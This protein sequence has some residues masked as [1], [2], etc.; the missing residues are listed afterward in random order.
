MEGIELKNEYPV[1]V[2]KTG[3]KALKKAIIKTEK[4]KILGVPLYCIIYKK[5]TTK[6]STQDKGE[7]IAVVGSRTYNDETAVHAMVKRLIANGYGIA[8]GGANGADHHALTAILRF[9]PQAGKIFTVGDRRSVAQSEAA[10]LQELQRKGGIIRTGRIHAK[11][12]RQEYTAALFQRTDEMMK[13]PAV[14]GAIAFLD[15]AAENSGTW[16]TVEAAIFRGKRA[17]VCTTDKKALQEFPDGYWRRLEQNPD[18]Y[19]WVVRYSRPLLTSVKVDGACRHIETIEKKHG[20][21]A[22]V[23]RSNQLPDNELLADAPSV[24]KVPPDHADTDAFP[25]Y[26][27]RSTYRTQGSWTIEVKSLKEAVEKVNPDQAPLFSNDLDRMIWEEYMNASGNQAF[28]ED[29]AEPRLYRQIPYIMARTGASP[30]QADDLRRS[31]DILGDTPE[32]YRFYFADTKQ[33]GIE[34]ALAYYH[35]LAESLEKVTQVSDEDVTRAWTYVYRA[36][37][38][39]EDDSESLSEE[40]FDD[41]DDVRTWIPLGEIEDLPWLSQQPKEYQELIDAIEEAMP[42]DLPALGKELYD[43]AANF[44]KAQKMVAFE[45]YARVKAKALAQAERRM[46]GDTLKVKKAILKAKTRREIARLGQRMHKGQKEGKARINPREWS[47]LWKVYRQKKTE[48]L[49]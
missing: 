24:S 45:T 19:L 8:S 44:T 9:N 43:K 4:G 49:A 30:V 10:P 5:A 22:L 36:E 16:Y 33:K 32:L 46:Q 12:S 14:K 15:P 40:D 7:Y 11:V 41:G 28:R 35:T 17:I 25:P 13:D 39:D 47:V 1:E 18:M 27:G 37:D 23:A 38:G 26:S 42:E 48:A 6:S 29:I 20:S 21:P 3:G 31:W 2:I 34:D